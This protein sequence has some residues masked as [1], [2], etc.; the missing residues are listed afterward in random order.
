MTATQFTLLIGLLAIIIVSLCIILLARLQMKNKLRT[1]INKNFE[2]GS[3]PSYLLI[4]VINF[5]G[6][7]DNILLT[8]NDYK[9]AKNRYEKNKNELVSEVK[10]EWWDEMKPTK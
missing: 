3:V 10:P 2:F 4:T 7:E 6:E 1:K 5:D 8:K 9:I